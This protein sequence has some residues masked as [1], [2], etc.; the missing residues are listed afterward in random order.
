MYH[1]CKTT[2]ISAINLLNTN[3][4]FDGQSQ[5]LIWHKRSLVPF[6][7]DA[8]RWLMGTATMKDV[9]SIKTRINQWIVTQSSQQE[10][11]VHII[12]ILNVT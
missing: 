11:L 3:P 1:S 9:K 6:L 4:S 7:G 5:S 8:F 10:T 12:S 2:I